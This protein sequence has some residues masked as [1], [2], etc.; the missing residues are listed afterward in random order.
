MRAGHLPKGSS[1]KRN[2]GQ[3]SR[4]IA[5]RGARVRGPL[6]GEA[7]EQAMQDAYNAGFQNGCFEGGEAL[8]TR[9][10]P[11]QTI[12]PGCTLAD[13]LTVGIRHLPPGVLLPVLSAAQVAGMLHEALES[14]RPFSVVRLGD[15]EL[16]TLAHDL[17]LPA[18]EAKR[19]GPF[20]PYAGVELPAPQ[21][22]EVLA[23]ALRKADIIGVP[24]S[25]HPSFQ[26]LLAPVFSRYGLEAA[27]MRLAFSTVNYELAEQG[28]LRPLLWGKRVLAV[29]NRAEGLG[30]VL[31]DSGIEVAG[32]V[33]PVLGVYDAE[34]VLAQA[35]GYDFDL[36]LVSA[37][38]AAVILCTEIAERLGKP[39]LDFGHVANQMESGK[40]RL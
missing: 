38:I 9:L 28:L 34:N 19:R 23:A 8:V 12:L 27:S 22:R 15:G 21:V 31:Q 33:T 18:D 2:A 29:G 6:D 16:L 10:L 37:G 25:R 36:A 14:R 40:I 39:A 26:G 17:I 4:A 20:L 13:L 7:F 5:E 1:E 24:Q 32:I 11:P 3:Q 35:A 30:R